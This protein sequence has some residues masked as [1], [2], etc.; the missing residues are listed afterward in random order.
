MEK[1]FFDNGFIFL[2]LVFITKVTL[3]TRVVPIKSC[4]L[5]VFIKKC[6]I[7]PKKKKKRTK[8]NKKTATNQITALLT[9]NDLVK[10]WAI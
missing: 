2:I 7:M 4:G 3:T 6:L 9:T 8:T 5:A 10:I 1:I